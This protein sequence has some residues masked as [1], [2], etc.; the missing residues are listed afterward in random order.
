MLKRVHPYQA[1][2]SAA[3]LI[4]LEIAENKELERA[5]LNA[6]YQRL[7]ALSGANMPRGTQD[8]DQE[9]REQS[10]QKEEK[11][12]NR[13]KKERRLAPLDLSQ[14][15][16]D[17]LN[18]R[19][20]SNFQAH[21]KVARQNIAARLAEGFTEADFYEVHRKMSALWLGTDMAQYLNYETLYGNKF[22]KYLGQPEAV[23][24]PTQGSLAGLTE[25]DWTAGC[26]D[27]G[28]SRA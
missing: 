20:G 18:K 28:V 2:T 16:L 25:A 9:P 11:K 21:G 23:A 10:S 12:K 1:P 24:K 19:A 17:D 27:D 4:L 7:I 6:A 5:V 22:A 13:E 14:R 26:D 8:H 3:K 15:I